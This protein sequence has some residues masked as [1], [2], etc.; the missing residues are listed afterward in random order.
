MLN[1]SKNKMY[2]QTEENRL[3]TLKTLV[4]PQYGKILAKWLVGILALTFLIMFVPWQQNI[5]GY[6][7][8][9]A[10]HPSNRPQNVQTTIAGRIESWKVREGQYVHAGD[11]LM[12]ISEIKDKFFDP[13][14][15]PR[16]QEQLFAK[17]N[18]LNA[19]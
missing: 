7:K 19:K 13:Q 2:S 10:F 9:T 18:S 12:V 6:G 8:V 4:T 11:T 3:Q 5:N 14:L 1:V 15:L 16:T 17:E